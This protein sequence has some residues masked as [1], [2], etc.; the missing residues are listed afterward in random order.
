MAPVACRSGD[1]DKQ[2]KL[3]HAQLDEITSKLL[4]LQKEK[5]PPL[6]EVRGGEKS[7]FFCNYD[8]IRRTSSDILGHHIL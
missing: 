3:L 5:L 1:L 6:P 7:F 2:N 8:E 4:A